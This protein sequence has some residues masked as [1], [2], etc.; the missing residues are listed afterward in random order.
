MNCTRFSQVESAEP[1]SLIKAWLEQDEA[2]RPFWP[3][4]SSAQG[5]ADRLSSS[6]GVNM[7]RRSLVADAMEG[8]YRDA[9]MAIPKLLDVFRSGAQA[10]TTGHQLV[11]MG[12]PAFFHYKIMSAIRWAQ[13]LNE[14]GVP[15]VPVFW[16][17]SEDHDFEEI[18]RVFSRLQEPFQWQPHADPK[19]KAVGRLPWTSNDEDAL[20]GWAKASGVLPMEPN[21]RSEAMP[22]AQRVRLWVHEMF[23]ELGVLVI[24]GDDPALK[25]IAGHLWSAEWTGEGIAEAVK[26]STTALEQAGWKAQLRVQEINLFHLNPQGERTRVD[27]WIQGQSP[28]AWKEQSMSN[29]SPNAALRPIYQEFLLESA[30]VIGGPG[31][32]AYWLQLGRAFQHH[33]MEQ[34]AL[35]LRDGALVW[36]PKESALADEVGWSPAIGRWRGTDASNRWVSLNMEEEEAV[37]RAWDAWGKALEAHAV[38]MGR[39][40][41]PT[42]LA[43]LSNMEKEWSRLQKKWRKSVRA[44]HAEKCQAL[45]Q[46]FDCIVFPE[47]APQER[48]VNARALVEDEAALADLNRSW[49]EPNSSQVGPVFLVFESL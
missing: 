49:F 44:R 2:I 9:G 19:G 48:V 18:A 41:L 25:E 12:G 4:P 21:T 46:V 37:H 29:W 1:D 33:G 20:V 35:M 27:R 14:Q 16:L 6:K 26:S 42:T 15:A 11:L 45:E 22:L 8:Q 39:D 34:P 40:V 43:S 47:G 17:A 23:G 38:G 10:V 31:E 3:F 24:D 36:S 13:S 7:D 32:I 5:I 30:A 28:L